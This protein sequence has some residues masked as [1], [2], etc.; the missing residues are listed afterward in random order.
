V[1]LSASRLV[2]KAG[3]LELTLTVDVQRPQGASL[4]LQMPRFGWLGEAEPYPDRQFPELKVLVDGAPGAI[5]DTFSAVVG[6]TDVSDAIRKSGVDPFAIADTPPFVS[7]KAGGAVALQTLERLGAVE[8]YQQN[9]IA[10][11]TVSR[12]IAIAL[13]AGAHSLS[14]S[15]QS[16]PSFDLETFS[17]VGTP[18]RLAPHCL[19]SADL[20]SALGRSAATRSFVVREYRVPVTL[21]EKPTQSLSVSWD[22]AGKNP[23]AGVIAFCGRDGKAVVNRIGPTAIPARADAKGVVH[24]MSIQVPR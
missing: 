10:R 8:K 22:E 16:R 13:K 7:A 15:Y 20:T 6:S 11:W 5:N 21:D 9:Y 12:K 17:R 14:L 4:V 23:G 18:A 2:A 1:A 3:R 19:T 24:V